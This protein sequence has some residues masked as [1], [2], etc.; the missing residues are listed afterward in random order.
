M[1]NLDEKIWRKQLDQYPQAYECIGKAVSPND[2]LPSYEF[3]NS[4]R[5]E[6]PKELYAYYLRVL[7][8]SNTK[9]VPKKLRLDMLKDVS[10]NDI[11]YQDEIE[12]INSWDEYITIYRGTDV[13]EIIPGLSW[14]IYKHIAESSDFNQGRIF[15]ATIPKN[16][17]LLFMSHEECEGEILV[18]VTKGYKIL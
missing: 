9:D 16:Q 11:M 1:S 5:K 17:I 15:E 14:T 13:N 10:W 3:L 18:D 12:Q 4:I 7:L 2:A 6:I 8:Q